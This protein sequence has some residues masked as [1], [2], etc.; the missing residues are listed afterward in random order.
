MID[1]IAERSGHYQGNTSS[2]SQLGPAYLLGGHGL[3]HGPDAFHAKYFRC[4]SLP[5]MVFE[6]KVP[7]V[8]GLKFSRYHRC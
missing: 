5:G 1:D 2:H 3:V 7:L 4:G 8:V 6:S